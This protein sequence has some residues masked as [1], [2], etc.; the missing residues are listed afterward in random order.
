M[1]DWIYFIGS[2]AELENADVEII[3]PVLLNVSIVV[4]EDSQRNL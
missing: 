4:E 3:A 2:E 1:R